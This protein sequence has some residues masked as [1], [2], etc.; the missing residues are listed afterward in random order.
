MAWNPQQPTSCA[1]LVGSESTYVSCTRKPPV[2]IKPRKACKGR[3]AGVPEPEELEQQHLQ[4]SGLLLEWLQ[5]YT[6]HKP[7]QALAP[8]EATQTWLLTG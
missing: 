4:I 8:S 1:R 7:G 2:H 5:N 3:R 6:A